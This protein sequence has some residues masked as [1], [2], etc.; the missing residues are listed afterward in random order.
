VEVTYDE[1]EKTWSDVTFESFTNYIVKGGPGE[2][3]YSNECG[4]GENGDE[5][6]FL[7]NLVFEG[8]NLVVKN[9]NAPYVNVLLSAESSITVDGTI[10]ADSIL[11]DLQNSD[12]HGFSIL[13]NDLADE[14]N[15]LEVSTSFFDVVSDAVITVAKSAIISAAKAVEIADQTKMC[16]IPK[17]LDYLRA[18]G[19][20]SN[21]VA[22][23]GN[24]LNLH[25]LIE[26]IDGRLL[27][28]K[29]YRGAMEKVIPAVIRDFLRKENLSR[30]HIWLVRAPYFEDSLASVTE[31][32]LTELGYTNFT[33]IPT[34]CVITCHGGPG[35]FGIV[36]SVQ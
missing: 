34:G 30:E 15:N 1:E 6:F 36:G 4:N 27:A 3:D 22:L 5:P 26:V 19:R 24:L 10:Q 14:E 25:P 2:I 23:V 33:W 12:S 31:K 13:E 18:G 9:I 35:A 28:K 16:F 20:C 17:N 29:K 21:A 11:L 8:E 32:T 7:A